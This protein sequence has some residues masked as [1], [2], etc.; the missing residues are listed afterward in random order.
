MLILRPLPLAMLFVG[1]VSSVWGAQLTQ[2][3]TLKDVTVYL[4]GASLQGEETL[5]LPAG[6]SEIIFTNIANSVTDDSI[7]ISIDNGVTVLSSRIEL[8]GTQ[9]N[10]L[11]SDIQQ[12]LKAARQE[13]AKLT[14]EKDNIAA[15]IKVLEANS[16]LTNKSAAEVG[17]YLQMVKEKNGE[18]LRVDNELTQKLAD[19]Q[20][21]IEKL[22]QRES[23]SNGDSEAANDPQVII[24]KVYVPKAVTAKAVVRY[25][26]PDATWTPLYDIHATAINQPLRLVYKANIRQYTGLTWKNVNL[27][28]STNEPDTHLTLPQLEPQY[29]D[30]PEYGGVNGSLSESPVMKQRS[31]NSSDQDVSELQKALGA[32]MQKTREQRA[33]RMYAASAAPVSP[34]PESFTAQNVRYALSLPWQIDSDNT[35]RTVVIKEESVNGKYRFFAIPKISNDAWLQVQIKEWEQ[36]NLIPGESQIFFG[37]NRTGVGYLQPPEDGKSLDIQL[38]RDPKLIIQRKAALKKENALSIFNDSAI[39]NFSYTLN[40]K[41]SYGEAVD[42]TLLDQIPVSANS[43]ITVE[44]MQYGQAQFDAKTG[45][46]TW[47]LKLSGKENVS[48]P[49]SYSVKYPKGMHPSGM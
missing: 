12:Q 46:L 31:E 39:R 11:P 19:N 49:F 29:V 21:E 9:P 38:N 35:A 34:Q 25:M 14:A 26:T 20:L 40:V 1:C 43:D 13:Q 30:V 32:E 3:L 48:L 8:Q 23:M 5:N 44:K 6:E 15:Q 10:T 41:N 18:L 22:E 24:A 47:T 16:T 33:G 36:L 4:H 2:P 37:N 45:E 42:I 7:A 28:L 17:K 27:V